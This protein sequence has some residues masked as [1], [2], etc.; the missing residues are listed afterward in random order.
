SSPRPGTCSLRP[1]PISR[2]KAGSGRDPGA[3]LAGVSF[4]REGATETSN[5]SEGPMA[6]G[7]LIHRSPVVLA[8]ADAETEN[9]GEVRAHLSKAWLDPDP[10]GRACALFTEFGMAKTGQHNG[11]LIY[12][13][14]RLRRFAIIADQGIAQAAGQRFWEK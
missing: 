10:F 2:A 14:L 8:L 6:P 4:C 3:W 9:T 5:R 7:E 13:N 11:V 1:K 12:V